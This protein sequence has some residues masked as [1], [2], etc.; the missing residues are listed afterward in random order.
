MLAK[1]GA[2][3]LEDSDWPCAVLIFK[4]VNILS[5]Q[6]DGTNKNERISYQTT[7]KTIIFKFKNPNSES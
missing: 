1:E 4:E 6:R 5:V 3:K 7:I 2:R